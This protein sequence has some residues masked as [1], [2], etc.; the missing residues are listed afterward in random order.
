[1]VSAR[2]PITVE[3]AVSLYLDDVRA[4]A[5][6]NRLSRVTAANYTRDLTEFTALAG[7]ATALPDLSPERLD[8][9]VAAYAAQPDGRYTRRPKAGP[10]GHRKTRGVGAQAR[11][12]QSVSRLFTHATAQ[13]WVPTNPMPAT[14]LKPRAGARGS[15]LARPARTDLPATTAKTLIDLPA[16]LDAAAKTGGYDR[17]DMR[18]ALRDEFLLRLLVEVGPRVSEIARANR[19]DLHTRPGGGTWLRL[20][21]KTRTERWVPLS[22]ATAEVYARY[23]S[24]ERPDPKPRIRKYTDPAGMGRAETT[25]PVEDA[26]RAL[27]LTWRGRR[28]TPRDIQLML[29]RMRDRLPVSVQGSLTPNRLRHTAATLLVSSGAADAPTVQALLGQAAPPSP[30]SAGP[31][32]D[33]ST[34]TSTATFEEDLL[35]TL[36][37]NPHLEA[38]MAAAIDRHPVTGSAAPSPAASSTARRRP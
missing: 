36:G 25:Q 16:L 27:V 20:Y 17:P 31:D 24:I 37:A 38:A 2:D 1:M 34:S 21:G 33:T 35:G 14:T 4:A 30:A 28:M 22:P 12:R 3:Q 10:D 8:A 13:Q 29:N 5:F 11:F 19:T 26:D 7:E 32:R 6:A 23:V 18:L 15:T 9:I